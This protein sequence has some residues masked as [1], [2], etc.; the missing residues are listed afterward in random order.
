MK[1]KLQQHI[2][3][4]AALLLCVVVA[5]PY[6]AIPAS[7]LV[8][9]GVTLPDIPAPPANGHTYWIVSYN[10]KYDTWWLYVVDDPSKIYAF[11]T[12]VLNGV[13]PYEYYHDK[14]NNRWGLN[15]QYSSTVN[16]SSSGQ[17]IAASNFDIK[18]T[19]GSIYFS[20]PAWCQTQD[21]YY[22]L[23]PFPSDINHP[24]T[25]VTYN[26]GSGLY[27][28]YLHTMGEVGIY[29]E[30]FGTKQTGLLM[31]VSGEILEYF[32]LSPPWNFSHASSSDTLRLDNEVIIYSSVDVM[33]YGADG[34]GPPYLYSPAGWVYHHPDGTR[35]Y[36]AY[37]LTKPTPPPSDQPSPTPAISPAPSPTP[38]PTEDWSVDKKEGVEALEDMT[39]PV[40]L[41][42]DGATAMTLLVSASQLY[43]LGPLAVGISII[44]I[45]AVVAAVIR[46]G[47]G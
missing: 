47:K 37:T 19:D 7:A 30:M 21:D 36:E 6:M 9:N 32:C 13:K 29:P 14:T 28:V 2:R 44:I 27:H 35:T 42:A 10:A 11:N 33:M 18:Y 26:Q 24:E 34:M 31:M 5:V 45:A 43:T 12:G 40:D 15:F 1:R 3:K 25:L 8:V 46:K 23:L 39:K 38:K 20:Y 16:M 22:G 4:I 17:Q 41:G